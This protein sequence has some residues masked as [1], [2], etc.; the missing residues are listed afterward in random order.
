MLSRL[1]SKTRG[2]EGEA[3]VRLLGEEERIFSGAYVELFSAVPTR[4]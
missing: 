2:R 3:R 4:M 1:I